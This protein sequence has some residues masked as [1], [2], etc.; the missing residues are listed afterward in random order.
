MIIMAL[1]KEI[2][3]TRR[4][5]TGGLD[6]NRTPMAG[7]RAVDFELL[8]LGLTPLM[9]SGRLPLPLLPGFSNLPTTW[10]SVGLFGGRAISSSSIISPKGLGSL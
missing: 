8:R 9:E 4:R 3:D 1:R 7:V 2:V 6:S 5:G 10:R